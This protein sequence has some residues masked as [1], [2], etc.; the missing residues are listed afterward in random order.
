MKE[1]LGSVILVLLI[2]ILIYFLN[3]EH[4]KEQSQQLEEYTYREY[5]P[6]LKYIDSE[7]DDMRDT[8]I[9]DFHK[10]F[11]IFRD[12]L[13]YISSQFYDP[14]DKMTFGHV[15]TNFQDMA[16]KDIYDKLTQHPVNRN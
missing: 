15:G 16:V 11:F 14:V 13:N 6:K 3:R 7:G 1:F 8:R 2:A 12:K 5:K 9:D 10:D 4:P